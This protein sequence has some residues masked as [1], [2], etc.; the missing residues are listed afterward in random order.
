MLPLFYSL[1]G[2]VDFYVYSRK[3]TPGRLWRKEYLERNQDYSSDHEE[4][5]DE[6]FEED[7]PVLDQSAEEVVEDMTPTSFIRNTLQNIYSYWSGHFITDFINVVHGFKN[8]FTNAKDLKLHI[9]D[10]EDLSH[11]WLMTLEDVEGSVDTHWT[12]TLL[13]N[14]NKSPY[15][16]DVPK[17]AVKEFPKRLPFKFQQKHAES[18]FTSPSLGTSGK[19][20]TLPS[21][22]FT[23]DYTKMPATEDHLFEYYGRQGTLDS[24]ITHKLLDLE[25]D[26]ISNITEAMDSLDVSDSSS[27]HLFAIKEALSILSDTNTLAMQSNYRSK[28]YS[29]TTACKAK[30]RIREN[31]LNRF[32]GDNCIKDALKGSSFFNNQLFGPISKTL[33]DKLDSYVNRSEAKLTPKPFH[34]RAP[35]SNNKRSR[36]S[37]PQRGARKASRSNYDVG[38]NYHNSTGSSSSA[39][40]LQPASNPAHTSGHS[41]SRSNPLFQDR[42][43]RPRR[44]RNQ[45]GR[46]SR[47]S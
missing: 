21:V 43:R 19:K 4:P 26:I 36:S 28:S 33:Q 24:Q 44:G 5:E 10:L 2:L 14:I 37:N 27:V 16:P 34:S 35:Y 40:H 20:I 3:A 45:R 29:I 17:G 6:D 12:D 8:R 23:Q 38:S 13:G 30:L 1:Y 41:G 7:E 9:T 32:Y 31:I 42:P 11:T 22:I 15:V 47:N 39:Y 25:G 46:G 18:Y